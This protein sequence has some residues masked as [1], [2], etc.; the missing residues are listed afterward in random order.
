MCEEPTLRSTE[1]RLQGCEKKTNK[2]K[3]V[4]KGFELYYVF[5]TMHRVGEGL[6]KASG[7]VESK[8]YSIIPITNKM[9]K[10]SLNLSTIC[11]FILVQGQC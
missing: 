1:A 8:A 2:K 9:S 7:L 10:K 6:E 5:R 3:K 4:E 11:V